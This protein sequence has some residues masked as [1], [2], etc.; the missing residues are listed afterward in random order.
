MFLFLKGS[1]LPGAPMTGRHAVQM[2]QAIRSSMAVI[3]FTPDGIIREASPQFCQLMGYT[4]DEL[5]GQHHKIFCPHDFVTSPAYTRFWS[6]LAAG[7]SFSDRF[8]RLDRNGHEVWLEASYI[9]VT[10][11]GSRVT[12]IV[13]I[14]TDITARIA[15]EQRQHSVLQAI[16]QSMAVIYF[17]L[18][19]EVVDANAQFTHTMGYRAQEIIGRHHAMFCD[20]VYVNS[21][22]YQAFWSSL[23]RGEYM[24]DR[25]ERVA[26][27]GRKVWLRATY[28]PLR[29]TNGRLYGFVK[30][31]SDITAS[32]EQRQAESQA[33]LMAHEIAGETD[34]R[35]QDAAHTVDQTVEHV[36]DI[37]HN[38][39]LVDQELK[40]LNEQ[41]GHIQDIVKVIQDI[42]AQTNLLA[43][44][45]AIEA[46]RAGPQGRGFAVVAGEV[47]S[48]SARTH[49]ATLN[50]A[51]VVKKNRA[52]TTQAVS[53]MRVSRERVDQ[54]VQAAATTRDIMQGIRTDARNV[55][56]AIA[57]VA[58]TLRSAA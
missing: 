5:I 48:L 35:A 30:V 37:A 8:M 32:V 15:Q 52:L 38:L 10:E 28:T 19:G 40:A 43:L 11:S 20:P 55:V 12:R 29:D 24:T 46:A 50:I 22:A 16:N 56:S 3:E 27:N 13:K 23:R 18:D 44:N 51:D 25:F 42:A 57:Q 41:S 7:Q 31:A 53:Q 36:Q 14:A 58:D 49:D 34:Q 39:T 21:P 47:R 26:R 4:E 2:I 45:A 17:N 1:A 54:C 33:A 6:E 9:P